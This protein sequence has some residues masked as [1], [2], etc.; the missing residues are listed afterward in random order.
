MSESLRNDGRVWVP[1][2]KGDDRTPGQ[3]PEAERD[4]YLERKYPTFGNLVPR[5]VASRAAKQ[6]ID[7]GRGVGRTGLAVYL[8]FAD[9]L[10]RQGKAKIAEKYGNLFD[11]YHHL[12]AE[13]PYRAPMRIYP[14]VHYTMGGLWVDYNLMT[15]IPGLFCLGEANFSDHGANRLG[16]SALMQ[17][18]ADG[19]FIVPYTLGGF[20]GATKLPRVDA[21]HQ[22]FKD[23][24]R[25][26]A[27]RVQKLLSIKGKRTPVSFHKELGQLMWNDCGMGRSEK[28]L[29]DALGRIPA[30]REEFWKNVIVTGSGED[31]NQTLERASRVADYLEFAE[32]L[33]RDALERRESCGGHFR[34][35][36]QTPEGEAKRDDANFSHA[37]VWEYAGEGRPPVQNREPLKFEH[38]VPSQRSYA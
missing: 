10:K 15:T 19:Y 5:D 31:F 8:D 17:G 29:Q 13:D 30:I 32:L 18:L 7:D 4:Y 20:F 38:V 1:K 12:T 21:G 28:G 6:M 16:A 33:A 27:G 3:I 2:R 37:A 36:S 23:A 22:A 14:A 9:A 11:M 35:E 25:A 26:A 34:E 24:E